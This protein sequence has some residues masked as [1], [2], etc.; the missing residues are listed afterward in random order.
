M[1]GRSEAH[2][3]VG[4]S[5][6][7]LLPKGCGTC[8]RKIDRTTA[9]AAVVRFTTPPSSAAPRGRGPSY[10]IRALMANASS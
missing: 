4:A 7:R 1:L 5:A 10:S 8:G 3:R 9:S 2:R 6:F